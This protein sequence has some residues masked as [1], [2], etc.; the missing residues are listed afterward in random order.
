MLQFSEQTKRNM[1]YMRNY[2]PR[3]SGFFGGFRFGNLLSMMSGIAGNVIQGIFNTKQMRETNQ[4]NREMV[5]AQ[6]VAAAAESEKSYQR[7]L[8]INQVADMR[9]AGMSRAGAI[10]ALNGGGSYQPAPVN[11]AQDQ[12]PQIDVSQAINAIQASAQIAMQEKQMK[13]QERMLDKQLNAQ[14]SESAKQRQH[15]QNLADTNAANVTQGQYLDYAKHQERLDFDKEVHEYNK[16]LI[17][18]QINKIKS[19]TKVDEINVTSTELDNI[20]KRLELENL[21]TLMQLANYETMN[22]INRMILDYQQ[23]VENH[24]LDTEAKRLQ[25]EIT[26]LTKDSNISF[27]NA[28]NELNTYMDEIHL[29]K[30]SR[31]NGFFGSLELFLNNY[32][33][34]ILKFK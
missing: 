17:Q 12:A 8:P 19:A 14:A 4:A 13:Q 1:E 7:S 9:A 33:P 15:E 26:E 11:T 24:T 30:N 3:G 20:R 28:R 10:N 25:N 27:T 6:N 23:A 31:A 32:M 21:P 34:A 18:A 2:S 5:D 29:R 16:P 22:R